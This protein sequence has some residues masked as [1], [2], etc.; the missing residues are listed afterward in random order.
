[1]TIRV[2]T[3]DHYTQLLV[4]AM[5]RQVYSPPQIAFW[6]EDTDGV[7]IDTL[8]VSLKA[9]TQGWNTL[10]WKRGRS[11]GSTRSPTGPIGGG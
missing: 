3:G 1:M 2:E 5:V 6:I 8:Y 4:F 7:F 9:G 10:P 11:A